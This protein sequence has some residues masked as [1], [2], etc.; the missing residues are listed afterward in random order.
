[1]RACVGH[2]LAEFSLADNRIG[3]PGLT[4]CGI[5]QG[6]QGIFPPQWRSK[7]LSQLHL[8]HTPRAPVR[9]KNLQRG[10]FDPALRAGVRYG[11]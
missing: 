10:R 11:P 4:P 2:T 9:I 1:M 5:E 3:D 6:V 8:Y 7:H